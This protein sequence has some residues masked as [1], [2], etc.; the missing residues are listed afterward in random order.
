MSTRNTEPGGA[1]HG[2]SLIVFDF[3][4]VIAD[5]LS[6]CA[7]ACQV[8]ARDMGSARRLEAN[9]FRDLDPLTFETLARALSLDPVAFADTVSRHLA[10]RPVYAP[11][12]P[13]MDQVIHALSRRAHI[14]IVSASRSD[15]IRGFLA[16]HDLAEDVAR[17]L[18][19]DHSGTKAQK[20][21]ALRRHW[22]EGGFVMIG[23]GISDM[24]AARA[25]GAVAVGVGWGWQDAR[26][27]GA[28]GAAVIADT[29]CALLAV[30]R[31]FAPR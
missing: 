12:F 8:A 15:V 3:D 20:L 17:V 27:L 5:S 6:P 31:G 28:H 19:R 24:H 11:L 18:G 23:D 22:P 26:Q 14:A 25:A 10:A 7:N 29:P 16:K 13:G 1:A 4:G 9:P 30:L 2:P 21:A